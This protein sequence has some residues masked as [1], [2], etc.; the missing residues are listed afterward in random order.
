M[1]LDTGLRAGEFA[2][3]KMADVDFTAQ[4]MLVKHAK[5]N[6]QWVVRFGERARQALEHYI[7]SFRG[8][9]PGYLLLTSR[10]SRPNS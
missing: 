5:G 10:G 6:K 9:A 2:N 7:R 3:L 1:L 8:D 4:R